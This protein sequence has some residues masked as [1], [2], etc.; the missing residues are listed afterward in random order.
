MRF[1]NCRLP[2]PLIWPVLVVC[3]IS[4]V[5]GAAALDDARSRE[6]TAEI[7]TT[8]FQRHLDKKKRLGI[9]PRGE[10]YDVDGPLVLP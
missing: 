3:G 2:R 6:F 1:E 7:W 8:A 10:P 9:P 4:G 5:A